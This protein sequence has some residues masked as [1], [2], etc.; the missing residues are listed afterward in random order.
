MILYAR[1]HIKDAPELLQMGLDA[2]LVVCIPACLAKQVVNMAQ[3]VSACQ[4][5]ANHDAERINATRNNKKQ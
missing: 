4:A 1:N 2:F 5:I 3:L